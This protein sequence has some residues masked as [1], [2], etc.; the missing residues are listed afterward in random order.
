[1]HIKMKDNQKQTI[2]L[3]K[4]MYANAHQLTMHIIHV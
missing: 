3:D 4:V 2:M 1:M